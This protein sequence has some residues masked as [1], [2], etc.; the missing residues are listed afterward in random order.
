MN[1]KLIDSLVYI[2]QSLS[3]EERQVLE[4]RLRHKNSTSKPSTPAPQPSDSGNDP[5][6][7][8]T[9]ALDLLQFAG[10][11]VGDDFEDCLHLVYETRSQ[12]EF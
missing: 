10:T 8:G 6:L 5:V 3:C 12:A 9:K 7:Q 4:A 1:T 2:I 11:W